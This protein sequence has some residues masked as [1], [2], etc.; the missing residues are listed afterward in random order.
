MIVESHLTFDG[1]RVGGRLG[2][3]LGGGRRYEAGISSG[4]RGWV[5]CAAVGG[6]RVEEHQGVFVIAVVVTAA[7]ATDNGVG[8]DLLDKAVEHTPTPTRAYVD[9]GFKD[10]VAIHGAVLAGTSLG[11][12]GFSWRG[13]VRPTVVAITV[14]GCHVILLICGPG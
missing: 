2:W 8:V 11:S 3:W 5:G 9:A 14:G 1:D 10:D 4:V 7:S 13:S 12:L 6:C